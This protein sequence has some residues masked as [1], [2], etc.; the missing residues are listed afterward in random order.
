MNNLKFERIGTV[1]MRYKKIVHETR[2]YALVKLETPT[3]SGS[4]HAIIGDGGE[5]VA[6]V[7]QDSEGQFLIDHQLTGG[8]VDSFYQD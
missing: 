2:E 7:S 3:L 6:T 1:L 4:T 8:E 5:I